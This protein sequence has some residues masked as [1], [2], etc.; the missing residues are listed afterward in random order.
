[1]NRRR[2]MK[3]VIS[4]CATEALLCVCVC[5]CVGDAAQLFLIVRSSFFFFYLQSKKGKRKKER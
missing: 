4:E 2:Q 5:V 3:T 1:M